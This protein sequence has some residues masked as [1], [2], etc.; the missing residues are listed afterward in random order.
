MMTPSVPWQTALSGWAR[1]VFG[2]GIM[3]VVT[4][5]ES[6]QKLVASPPLLVSG[7]HCI[8]RSPTQAI[9]ARKEVSCK[10]WLN[11]LYSRL[12]VPGR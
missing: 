10:E 11:R 3:M 4:N 6:H 8:T 9:L 1:A 7:S 2:R 5:Q 12:S